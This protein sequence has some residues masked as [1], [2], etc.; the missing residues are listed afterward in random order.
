LYTI[1]LLTA[2]LKTTMYYGPVGVQALKTFFKSGSDKKR[3]LWDQIVDKQKFTIL[4]CHYDNLS[5]EIP[6]GRIMPFVTQTNKMAD[7]VEK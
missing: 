1:I 2:I 5:S 7:A 6:R 3:S 4:L